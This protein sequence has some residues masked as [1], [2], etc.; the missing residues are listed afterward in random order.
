MNVA[1][2][3]VSPR[4]VW[5]IL[6]DVRRRNRP[7][8]AWLAILALLFAQLATAAYACPQMVE[9][10]VAQ[11][12]DCDHESTPRPNLCE[13]HCDY[14]NAS[15]DTGKAPSAP[16]AITSQVRPFVLPVAREL[17]AR[18]SALEATATGPPPTRYTVLRI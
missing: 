14:G 11:S 1:L 13:R 8:A 15:H 3:Q 7:F 6:H 10:P 2:R 17:D 5:G 18:G 16:A 4:S 9:V 12:S